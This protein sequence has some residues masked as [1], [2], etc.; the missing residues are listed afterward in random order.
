M[1][2][3]ILFWFYKEP[4]ICQNRLE[5]LRQYNPNTP[6]YGVYGG[7][8]A[9][10]DRYKSQLE[11]YLDDFYTFSEPKD[12]YW[13]WL[14]GDLILT[15]W[16]RERGRELPFD[17]V[18][19]VQWD[20]LIFGAI[21]QLFA[22]LEPNQ[23]LLSGLRPIAE[24]ENN[25]HWVTPK[26][27]DLRL[28]Y[29]QFLEHIDKVY[30]YQQ[31]PMACIFIVACLPRI[32]LERYA[33]IEQ[34][35]L[36]FVEYRIPIYAQIFGIPICEQHP[37]NAWWIDVEPTFHSK[38]L[39]QRAMNRFT[40]R[41]NPG[42]LHH[43]LD[44]KHSDIS[45]IPIF[46]H[47]NMAKGDRIFHPYQSMFPLKNSQWLGALIAEFTRDLDWISRRISGHD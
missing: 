31:E 43:T 22:M 16:Y 28:R 7:D 9:A 20:M 45:L 41:F 32:F 30:N 38:D 6:I 37:F 12:T 8:L 3:A 42:S 10:V 2:L 47:L 24:I 27:A 33:T 1:K 13:K 18:V 11:P 29:L 36:G 40:L 14:Q 35:E 34:P 26:L 23:I 21:E 44:P 17:T 25:W 5:I 4:E 46:K 19:V 15:H 39:V